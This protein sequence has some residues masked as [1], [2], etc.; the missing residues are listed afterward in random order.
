MQAAV[1]RCD[2]V[3]NSYAACGGQFSV[4]MF[5]E[6][7]K[8]KLGNGAVAVWPLDQKRKHASKMKCTA[9][10]HAYCGTMGVWNK[11]S[12]IRTGNLLAVQI[13]IL[14]YAVLCCVTLCPLVFCLCTCALLMGKHAYHVE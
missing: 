4:I 5:A 8:C 1:L 13:I 11:A 2:T 7:Y 12:G 6:T 14:N 9:V 3:S 10:R